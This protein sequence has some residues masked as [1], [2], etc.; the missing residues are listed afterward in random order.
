MI[1]EADGWTEF[2]S[3]SPDRDLGLKTE[4]DTPVVP[5]VA[6]AVCYLLLAVVAAQEGWRWWTRRRKTHV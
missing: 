1:K 4:W 2:L 5:W 6:Y 3:P